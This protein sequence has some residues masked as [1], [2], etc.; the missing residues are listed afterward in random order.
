MLVKCEACGKF[1][2]KELTVEVENI[3][4]KSDYK[5]VTVCNDCAASF[6]SLHN[7]DFFRE[8][9]N[10]YRRLAKEEKQ[11][12]KQEKKEKADD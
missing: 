8:V 6:H 4:G 1:V 9:H 3:F 12:L 5:M 10:E 7:M 11:K 2:Q